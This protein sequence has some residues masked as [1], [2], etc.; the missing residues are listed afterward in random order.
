MVDS[1]EKHGEFVREMNGQE[2]EQS[3][4]T[5]EN[6]K[7]FKKLSLNHKTR[8]FHDWNELWTSRQSKSPKPLRQKL[9]NFV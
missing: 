8:D 5:R 4:W 7:F 6:W 3:K 9:E 2:N 1:C